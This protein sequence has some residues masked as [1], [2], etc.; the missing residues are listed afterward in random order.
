MSKLSPQHKWILIILAIVAINAL[1]WFYGL[2]PSLEKI[3]AAQAKLKQAEQKRSRL[4]QELDQLNAIDAVAL[5]EEWEVISVQIPDEGL[6]RE[7]IHGL[8]DMAD[9][10]GVPLPSVSLSSP[11]TVGPYSFVTISTNISGDYEQLK[12]FLIAL[13]QHE[14]L[15]L[16]R[17]YSFNASEET[18]D[19]ALS[20][21][22]FAEEFEPLTPHEAPGR[23]SPFKVR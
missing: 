23:D 19:C 16:V 7:F 18:I 17:S 13:E 9:N 10:M 12:A 4:Q 22:V 5:E 2:S 6:L 1:V 3:E 14:R 8:V 15:V 11:A 20:F 21:T